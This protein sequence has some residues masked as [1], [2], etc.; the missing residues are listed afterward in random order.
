MTS[1]S[2]CSLVCGHEFAQVT[3]GGVIDSMFPPCAFD[4][5]ILL[6]LCLRDHPSYFASRSRIASLCVTIDETRPGSVSL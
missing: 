3:G 1:G 6:D 5:I 4:A 2:V